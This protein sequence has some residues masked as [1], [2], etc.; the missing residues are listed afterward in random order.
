[1]RWIVASLMVLLTGALAGDQKAG[2]LKERIGEWKA[3]LAAVEEVIAHT[4]DAKARTGAQAQAEELREHIARATAELKA[5]HAEAQPKKLVEAQ[6]KKVLDVERPKKPALA[7]KPERALKPEKPGRKPEGREAE[8]LEKLGR[9]VDRV[10]ELRKQAIA[11]KR[12]GE[13]DRSRDLWLEAEELAATLKRRGREDDPRKGREDDPGAQT[14]RAFARARDALGRDDVRAAGQA[15]GH[16]AGLLRDMVDAPDMGPE[17]LR[18]CR[19]WIGKLLGGAEEVG[20][21]GHEDMARRL[22]EAGKDLM[23][24]LDRRQDAPGPR[25]DVVQ[26]IEG[27][28]AEQEKVHGRIRELERVRGELER[29]VR[30]REAGVDAAEGEKR[31]ALMRE[32]RAAAEKREHVSAE[33]AE[34]RAHAAR[35]D[36]E[37]GR[38]EERLRVAGERPLRRDDAP[39]DRATVERIGAIEREVAE[40]AQARAHLRGQIAQI[41]KRFAGAEGPRPELQRELERLHEG[42]AAHQRAFQDLRRRR[43]ELGE[44]ARSAPPPRAVERPGDGAMRAEIEALR[45][46]VRELR[47]LLQDALRKD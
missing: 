26:R 20:R 41:E 46:E 9:T 19:G 6:P 15:F 31:E 14:E 23:A 43:A 44:G 47:R 45:A 3:K 34:L 29:E 27:L 32:F 22:H 36:H 40:H 5:V 37:R 35:L 7:A 33:L 18:W 1:M 30:R 13:L 39:R 42:L 10:A 16:A 17:D 25:P 11:A 21:R 24:A 2:A 4:D 8:D 38:I 28:R 12:A